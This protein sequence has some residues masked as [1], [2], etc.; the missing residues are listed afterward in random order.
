MNFIKIG[1]IHPFL[2]F[3]AHLGAPKAHLL[4]NYYTF[5]AKKVTFWEVFHDSAENQLFTPK[6][7]FFAEK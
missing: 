5:K 1:E 6:T 4:L 2:V 3:W 7:T